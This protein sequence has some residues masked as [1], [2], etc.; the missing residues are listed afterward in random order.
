MP[1]PLRDPERVV[2]RFPTLATGCLQDELED[3]ESWLR[4]MMEK[5]AS[6]F[7]VDHVIWPLLGAT[8]VALLILVIAGS[9]WASTK[10]ALAIWFLIK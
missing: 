10:L 9:L 2:L 1:E 4:D 3:D 7:F 5:S 6:E 8:I